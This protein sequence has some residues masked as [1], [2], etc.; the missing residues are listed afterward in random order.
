MLVARLLRTLRRV[1]HPAGP[2][3]EHAQGAIP[4]HERVLGHRRELRQL[5]SRIN[6]RLR[7]GQR[8]HRHELELAPVELLVKS[9][10]AIE[11]VP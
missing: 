7:I 10:N 2:V 6:R 4:G 1:S 9:G 3:S 11:I 5:H 8:V